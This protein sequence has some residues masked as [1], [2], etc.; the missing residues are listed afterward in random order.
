M[1]SLKQENMRGRLPIAYLGFRILLEHLLLLVLQLLL[2]ECAAAFC[3]SDAA[4]G[5]AGAAL[6]FVAI[7]GNQEHHTCCCEKE[8]GI[9]RPKARCH[10]LQLHPRPGG[11]PVA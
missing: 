2:A 5:S 4:P 11:I 1:N 8:D 7:V 6:L 3:T 9:S 10:K